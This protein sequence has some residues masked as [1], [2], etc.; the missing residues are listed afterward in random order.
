MVQ[1]QLLGNSSNLGKSPNILR[2]DPT[3][4]G[5]RA[6]RRLEGVLK[7]RSALQSSNVGTLQEKVLSTT[8]F[9]FHKC[10]NP[11]SCRRQFLISSNASH[12]YQ[13]VNYVSV[14]V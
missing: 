3:A 5:S 14:L 10:F 6:R 4:F 8:N 11:N 1:N 2:I 13:M 7:K 12:E 9:V